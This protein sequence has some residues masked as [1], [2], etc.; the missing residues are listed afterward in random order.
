MQIKNNKKT[1]TFFSHERDGDDA[2][3]QLGFVYVIATWTA[4]TC[5][6]RWILNVI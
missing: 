2:S 6:T 1:L 5:A 4:E 3:L